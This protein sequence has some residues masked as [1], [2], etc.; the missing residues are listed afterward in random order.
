MGISIHIPSAL[1]DRIYETG[2]DSDPRNAV[3]ILQ[4]IR[5]LINKSLNEPGD[6]PSPNAIWYDDPINRGRHPAP[7]TAS[8]PTHDDNSTGVPCTCGDPDDRTFTHR[9]HGR[10]CLPHARID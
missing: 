8:T 2:L 3:E 10:P 5:G 4:A 6:G 9:N 1:E 7:R